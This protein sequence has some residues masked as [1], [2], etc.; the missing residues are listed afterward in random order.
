MQTLTELYIESES[1]SGKLFPLRRISPA[2][3]D[4]YHSRTNDLERGEYLLD[5]RP[6][7]IL[8]LLTVRRQILLYMIGFVRYSF[9][10]APFMIDTIVYVQSPGRPFAVLHVSLYK[11]TLLLAIHG[12]FYT[13]AFLVLLTIEHAHMTKEESS[14]KTAGE[15][16]LPPTRQKKTLNTQISRTHVMTH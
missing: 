10:Y 4:G 11:S 12:L 9:Y 5:L 15:S 8:R 7:D 2:A 16:R 1:G 14:V 6:I 3:S 13:Q